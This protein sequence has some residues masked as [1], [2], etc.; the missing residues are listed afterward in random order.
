MKCMSEFDD[1]MQKK[2]KKRSKVVILNVS[3]FLKFA[4]QKMSSR[5]DTTACTVWIDLPVS[6][7]S[8][9]ESYNF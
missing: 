2:K 6:Q 8:Q 1:V 3:K 5:A 4:M 7:C 9:A